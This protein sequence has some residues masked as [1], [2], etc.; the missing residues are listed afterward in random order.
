M[1][2]LRKLEALQQSKMERY[3]KA[4]KHALFMHLKQSKSQGVQLHLVRPQANWLKI[5][6]MI[7]LSQATSL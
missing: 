3:I 1:A 4:S 2:N 6:K 7:G 5:W